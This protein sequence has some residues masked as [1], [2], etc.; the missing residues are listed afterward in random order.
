[1]RPARSAA[2]NVS[3]RAASSND[4]GTVSTTVCSWSG[5]SGCASSQLSRTRPS[6]RALASTGESRG[7][8]S[9]VRPQGS[10]A[11]VRSMRAY[12]SQLFAEVMA[13]PGTSAPRVRAYAPST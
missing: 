1:M 9:S 8:S 7:S 12:D 6:R 5:A 4:A 2:S 13:R 10:T 3:S 11:A